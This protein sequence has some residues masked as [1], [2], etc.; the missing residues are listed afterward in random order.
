MAVTLRDALR[1]D[2]TALEELQRRASTHEPTYREQ[3]LA[4]PDAIELPVEQ[5]DAGFVRVAEVEGA[6]AGFAVLLP[7]AQGACELDGLF[8]EPGHWRAGIGRRLIEDA[9][10]IAR[11]RGATRIDVI[12]NP[13]AVAFYVRVGFVPGETAPTRFGP[14][15]RMSLRVTASGGSPPATR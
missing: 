14:A 13:D 11:G 8:V 4:H 15:Q 2:R 10:E 9:V 5:I 1:K 12:V 3:L 6:T 7:A